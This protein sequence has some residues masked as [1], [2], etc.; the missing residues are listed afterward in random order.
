MQALKTFFNNSPLFDPRSTVWMHAIQV[1]LIVVAVIL[2]L[3]RMTMKVPT[4]RANT[5]ALSMGMKS[6]VIISYE[7]LTERVA[8]FRRWHSLKANAIL[9]SLEV[10]FWAAVMFLI[11]KANLTSCSGASCALSW[12]V[13]VLALILHMLY[14][15]TAVVAILDFRHFKRCGEPRSSKKESKSE[16][17][18]EMQSVGD[19]MVR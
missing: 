1:V 15:Q 17:D 3:V 16:S 10:V 4:T 2:T 6:L 11:F 8:K 5:M 13:A 19:V 9:N 18:S 12:V 14:F 7:L